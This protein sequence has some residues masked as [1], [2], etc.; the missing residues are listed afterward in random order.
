MLEGKQPSRPSGRCFNENCGQMAMFIMRESNASRRTH[1]P[2]PPTLFDPLRILQEPRRP[3]SELNRHE[4]EVEVKHT[5]TDLLHALNP[6][7]F[8]SFRT[9]SSIL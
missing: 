4:I 7:P 9:C 2:T 6:S 8:I 5:A 3:K 1:K